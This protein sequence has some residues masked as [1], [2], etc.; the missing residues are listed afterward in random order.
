MNEIRLLETQEGIA[1]YFLT[2]NY[3]IDI[4]FFDTGEILS[5][6]KNRDSSV[7]QIFEVENLVQYLKFVKE[8]MSYE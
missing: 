5:S 6:I 8:K 7:A 3:I 4:E 1:L 2:T